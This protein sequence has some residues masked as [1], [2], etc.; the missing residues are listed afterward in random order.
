MKSNKYKNNNLN[1]IFFKIEFSPILKLYGT[2][3]SAKEFPMLS[4]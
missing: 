3:D 2:E 4:T 1:E